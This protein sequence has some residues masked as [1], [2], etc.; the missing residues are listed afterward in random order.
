[1]IPKPKYIENI[2]SVTKEGRGEIECDVICQCGS[3]RFRGYKNIAPD[4]EEQEKYVKELARI[5]SRSRMLK[6]IEEDGK[7]YI[8][9]MR[10]LFGKKIGERIEARDFDYTSV[11]SVRCVECG[12]E[13]VLFDSRFY[14]YDAVIPER[15]SR[16]DEVRYEFAPI[17]WRGDDDGIATFSVHIENDGSL[18][19]LAKDVPDADE[20]MYSNAFDWIGIKAKNLKTKEEKYVLDEDM[21]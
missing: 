4:A 11:L 1:M 5:S 12:S 20:Q 3:R 9:G 16:Y 7:R 17:S 8:C 15:E 10:G 21:V 6:T 14:G 13:Y 18:E 2:L 19:R